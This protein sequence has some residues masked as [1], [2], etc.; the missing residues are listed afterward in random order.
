MEAGVTLP[1]GVEKSVKKK[2]NGKTYVYF[3]WNPGRGTKRQ[4][5]RIKLP[6]PEKNLTA[7]SQELDRLQK[8]APTSCP[9][10]SIGD[11]SPALSRQRGI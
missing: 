1:E 11:L 8:L 5:D 3:Y 10:G 6:N 2:K 4:G 9:P 7:F